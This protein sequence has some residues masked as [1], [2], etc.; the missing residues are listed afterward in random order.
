M[1][2]PKSEMAKLK[3]KMLEDVL[4]EAVFTNVKITKE[5]RI[6]ATMEQRELRKIRK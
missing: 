5:F 2:T 1:P 3:I 6:T 4:K